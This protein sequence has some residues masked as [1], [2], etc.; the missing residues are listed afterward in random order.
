MESA[1]GSQHLYPDGYPAA[2]MPLFQPPVKFQLH[3]PFEDRAVRSP[4]G[5]PV[6][7]FVNPVASY[8]QYP[9]VHSTGLPLL[10]PPPPFQPGQ[11]LRQFYDRQRVRVAASPAGRDEM[12]LLRTDGRHDDGRHDDSRG[13]EDERSRSPDSPTQLTGDDGA[14]DVVD[15]CTISPGDHQSSSPAANKCESVCLFYDCQTTDVRIALI[16]VIIFYF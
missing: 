1:R 13:E 6:E 10:L 9:D 16:A 8:L 15:D 14:A 2:A 4:D 7:P 3:R 11:H 12:E 5:G